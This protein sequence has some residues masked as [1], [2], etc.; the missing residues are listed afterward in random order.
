MRFGS[1]IYDGILLVPVLFVAALVFLAFARDARTGL[2]HTL[3]Q[4]WLFAVVGGY[5][6]VCWTRG[7]TLAMKTWHLRVARSDGERLRSGQAWLRYVLA[8]GG[9][10]ALGAGFF[11]IFFDRERQ[12]L[13][14]RLSGTRIFKS[15]PSRQ[16]IPPALR[17]GDSGAGPEAQSGTEQR[18]QH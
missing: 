2:A 12:Y 14:D 3:F 8:A 1:L 11:W 7:G 4:L 15:P 13:H 10:F 6:V 5:F 9:L 17:S 18:A 16:E